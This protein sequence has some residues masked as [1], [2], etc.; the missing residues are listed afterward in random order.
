MFLNNWIL[1]VSKFAI[2]NKAVDLRKKFSIIYRQNIFGG[3]QSRSGEGS[4]MI[5]TATIRKQLPLTLASYKINTMLDAPCGDWFWMRHTNLGVKKYIGVDIVDELIKSN[6]RTFGNQINSFICRNIVED[7]LPLVDLIFCRDCLVHLNFTD[8]E[9]VIRN[10]KRSGSK[11]LLTTTFVRRDA[12][13]DLLGDDIWRTIN[14][15]ISPFNFPQP[16]LLINENCT[17]IG[18]QYDDK[19]LGLWLLE[20]INI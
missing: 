17:E 4:D 16:L 12:N 14:L 8:I 20:D 18:G 11:Y 19:S 7:D 9:K 1:K 15:Q 3:R 10:F 13:N 6:Q 5:Q 2:N